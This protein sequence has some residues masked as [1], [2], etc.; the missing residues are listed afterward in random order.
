[1]QF[2]NIVKMMKSAGNWKVKSENLPFPCL[3]QQFCIPLTV[4][5]QILNQTSTG[6]Y[7]FAKTL[8]KS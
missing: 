4:P 5:L 8:R 2:K 7:D 6:G 3:L 1:M